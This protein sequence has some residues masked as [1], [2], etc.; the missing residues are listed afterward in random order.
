MKKTPLSIR[1]AAALA[2]V[3]LSAD[4]T[5]PK[6]PAHDAKPAAHAS[7]AK[8]A[9]S[10]VDAKT[11][12]AVEARMNEFVAAWN[13]HDPKAM[14]GVWLENCDLINPFG[15]KANGRAEIEK[16][17]EQ[18]QGGPM[19]ASTYKIDSGTMRRIPGGAILA[20]WDCTITGIASPD[21]AA[22]PPFAHHVTGIYVNKGGRWNASSVRA[23]GYMPP[24]G[25]GK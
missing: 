7:H 23:F 19:K 8:G 16:L 22:V 10:E 6:A 21:G 9:A 25:P 14:S 13:K 12:K 24:P 18:E 11:R 17:F 15:V 5:A 3:P 20:D 4:E 1:L 2:S